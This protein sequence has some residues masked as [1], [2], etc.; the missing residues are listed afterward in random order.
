MVRGCF[1]F[2]ETANLHPSRCGISFSSSTDVSF[3]SILCFSNF[4]FSGEC[5]SASWGPWS[6]GF[7]SFLS[8]LFLS[9]RFTSPLASLGQASLFV[10]SLLSLA[11][12]WVFTLDLAV[13]LATPLATSPFWVEA[14]VS[15][16]FPG[17]FSFWVL[18]SSSFLAW[19]CNLVMFAPSPEW[20]SLLSNYPH[21]QYHWIVSFM[22]TV[23]YRE[24]WIHKSILGLSKMLATILLNE[25]L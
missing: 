14:V 10:W 18:L 21:R 1:V 6:G 22:G 16:V 8:L 17:V 2:T 11:E 9:T 13:S 15:W 5:C 19:L 3:W 25:V 12:F 4:D 24:S 23:I 20:K 7:V